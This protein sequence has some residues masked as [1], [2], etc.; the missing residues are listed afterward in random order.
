MLLKSDAVSGSSAYTLGAGECEGKDYKLR[1]GTVVWR[2][3]G[4]VYASSNAQRTFVP[5]VQ[6][7]ARY[8]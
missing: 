6:T 2:N 8:T 4:G 5:E 3:E 7:E 1:A